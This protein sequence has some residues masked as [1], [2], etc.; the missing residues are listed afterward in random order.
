[1]FRD[2]LIVI[3]VGLGSMLI[4]LA[5]VYLLFVVPAPSYS[6]SNSTTTTVPNTLMKNALKD[7]NATEPNTAE[8]IAKWYAPL[9]P[10]TL[11]SSSLQASVADT[12]VKR[13]QGLSGTP[14]IPT[15][16]VKL[17]VFDTAA[18]W[19]FWMKDMQYPI[20]IIW[21]DEHKTVVHIESA[22]APETYPRSFAPATPAKYVIETESGFATINHI[23][24]GAQA[25]W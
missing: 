23:A 4:L 19:A 5:L 13:E 20:D 3:V 7:V 18:P 25:E 12:E 6:I 22:L 16:V 14:Y 2:K 24:I 17:F 15:G 10:L 9:I 21:L 8:V 11:G 1:M